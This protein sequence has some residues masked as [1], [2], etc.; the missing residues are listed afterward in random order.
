MKKSGKN[1]QKKKKKAKKTK[2]ENIKKE[3]KKP[4]IE[5]HPASEIISSNEENT[6][7]IK[8]SNQEILEKEKKAKIIQGGS[9]TIKK[10]IQ[11]DFTQEEE[12][13]KT[14]KKESKKNEASKSNKLDDKLKNEPLKILK[15]Q[16]QDILL[17]KE[18]SAPIALSKPAKLIE[19]QTKQKEII[20]SNTIYKKGEIE[21]SPNPKTMI[22]K[23]DSSKS[24]ANKSQEAL[25]M[26][27]ASKLSI[28]SQKYQSNLENQKKQ[29]ESL[30]DLKNYKKKP[31]E[32]EDTKDNQI[33]NDS[34]DEIKTEK[35]KENENL[36]KFFENSNISI[37]SGNKLRPADKNL[38][39]E[40]T[41]DMNT[42][43]RADDDF[44]YGSSSDKEVG[45]SVALSS[46]NKFEEVEEVERPSMQVDSSGIEIVK[47]LG[48]GGEAKVYLGK[49]G[50]MNKYVVMKQFEVLT[51][52]DGGK[53][54]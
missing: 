21:K 7:E 42:I 43:S 49:I 18:K 35:A 20:Q 25:T 19:G 31:L 51:D 38:A 17:V 27:G 5:L 53:L 28:P 47:F 24:E 37:K 9:K 34:L 12:I 40:E 11:S 41:V 45:T 13:P 22:Y 8:S 16:D 29:R 52:K 14:M 1:K 3:A 39:D 33:Q 4:D 2:A 44:D 6:N 23:Q 54:N 15:K 46:K 26:K 48:S 10:N 50:G 36:Q 32:P 30:L